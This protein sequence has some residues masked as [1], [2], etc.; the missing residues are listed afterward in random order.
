NPNL[1]PLAFSLWRGALLV[2]GGLALSKYVLPR[3][4]RAVAKAPELVLVSALA[5]CFFLAGAASL[6]GLS[7]EMG[8]LIAGVSLSTFPYN[9]DVM[10]KAVSIR[11]F[12]VPLF[13]V[14]LGLQIPIPILQVVVIAL[15]ASA[16]V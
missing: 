10:A 13:F 5:W 8:A 15:A 2:V 4:F 1:L 11:D 12:F 7:K 14:A 6:I 9:L 3:I 16:F